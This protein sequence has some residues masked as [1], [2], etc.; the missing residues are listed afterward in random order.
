MEVEVVIDPVIVRRNTGI[1]AIKNMATFG[2]FPL[3]NKA[4]E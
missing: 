3:Y 2:L 1:Q 4:R